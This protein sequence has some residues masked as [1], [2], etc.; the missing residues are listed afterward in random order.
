VII[1]ETDTLTDVEIQRYIQMPY[2]T[3]N[4]GGMYPCIQFNDIEVNEGDRFEFSYSFRAETD[5]A[6]NVLFS[7]SFYLFPFSSSAYFYQLVQFFP[8][9]GADPYLRWNTIA[10]PTPVPNQPAI[11]EALLSTDDMTDWRTFT[12]SDQILDADRK[13]PA[14]PE[15]GA[16]AIQVVGYQA[17][18]NVVSNIKDISFTY[19]PY[20]N[21]STRVIGQYNKESQDKTIKNNNDIE[22][23]FDDS[24]KYSLSGVLYTN[25]VTGSRYITR[26]K[27]WQRYTNSESLSLSHINTLELLQW[28]FKTRLIF[29]GTLKGLTFTKDDSKKLLSL[30]SILALES[31]EDKRFVFGAVSIDYKNDEVKVNSMFELYEV[32]EDSVTQTYEFKY[33]YKAD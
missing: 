15:D 9:G 6:N 13:F 30:L 16:L 32:G 4:G 3:T 1:V 7:N 8:G 22:I 2:H 31:E 11:Q 21:D 10:T 26:T 17:N 20:I 14:F 19:T 29:E 25:A 12:L 23:F 24:P 18:E 33:L 5:T 27:L 28:R